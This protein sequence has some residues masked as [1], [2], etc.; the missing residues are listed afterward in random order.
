M[1]VPRD[2]FASLSLLNLTHF[3]RLGQLPSI[4][5][6]PVYPTS[7][8]SPENEFIRT[9]SC[10]ARAF[11]TSS[12]PGR[13]MRLN[14]D[15]DIRGLPS[16]WDSWSAIDTLLQKSEFALIETVDIRIFRRRA[17]DPVP[18]VG[19]LTEKLLLLEMSGKLI[20]RIID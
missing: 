13:K 9:Y 19:L 6:E 10:N 1:K 14:I 3:S 4:H 15:L 17:I 8:Q 5:T 2:L 18:I 12:E 20:A 16:E 7:G 11:P